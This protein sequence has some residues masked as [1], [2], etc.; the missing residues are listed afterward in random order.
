MQV[1]MTPAVFKP[2][3]AL[4]RLGYSVDVVCAGSFCRE[5]PL[6]H[7][8]VP[9]AERTFGDIKRLEPPLGW[10]GWAQA[11]FKG[12]ARVPDLMTVLHQPAYEE[13]MGRDLTRY[14]AVMTWSPF[15]SVNSVMAKVKAQRKGVR[16]I[17][18]FSDPWAGNPLE[19]DIRT[20]LWNTWHEPWSI[21]RADHI[22]HSSPHSLDLMFRGMRAPLRSKTGVLP[23]V[24]NRDLYPA[25]PK[26]NNEHIVLRY[27]GVL[28]GRRSPEPVFEAL[29]RLF[30]RR[31]A[32]RG[33]VV[34]EL[35]GLVPPEMLQTP[36]A[37]ALPAGT[38]R[39]VAQVGYLESLQL[40]YDADVLLLI[41]A[42]VRRNLFLASKVADY[43]GAGRP[44]VG[45]VP[46][47]ASQEAMQSLGAWHARP[48]DITGIESA[49]EGAIDHV[50]TGYS[51]SNCNESFRSMLSGEHVA[52]QF[53]DI[54]R[55]G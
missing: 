44:I 55:K 15:H 43:V 5:L 51:G 34:V 10:R 35:V 25:R 24:Y 28:Y 22:I 39:T 33:Q 50:R 40:M 14:E 42:D 49:L 19:I 31:P 8:L 52:R 47:G 16:W 54:I 41:E 29:G 46:P 21:R 26:A 48:S 7:G 32:L 1:Q 37:L 30:Q 23:H 6:D 9:F 27:V 4:A 53:A 13:L 11:R 2:M 36:A 17:A 18:Q 38:I 12:L 20:K 3:A 45:I